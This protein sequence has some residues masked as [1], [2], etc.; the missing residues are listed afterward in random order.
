MSTRA[1]LVLALLPLLA[2]TAGHP[3]TASA[4]IAPDPRGP[5]PVVHRTL[6]S[7]TPAERVLARMSLAQQ[8]G[9]LFMVGTSATRAD[10][11]TLGQIGGCTWAT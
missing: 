6:P 11:R 4:E 10:G 8:V 5:A 9:Q 1:R 2:M 3:A 7:L